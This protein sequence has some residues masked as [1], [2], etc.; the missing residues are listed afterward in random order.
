MAFAQRTD[1]G[2]RTAGEKAQMPDEFLTRSQVIP[3][4]NV[5]FTYLG[6][7]DIK[8]N[9]HAGGAGGDTDCCYRV[10]NGD[11]EI[12]WSGTDGL[13]DTG[14]LSMD[15]DR[16]HVAVDDEETGPTA[17]AGIVS[18]MKRYYGTAMFADIVHNWALDN[19]NN[20]TCKFTDTRVFS[21]GTGGLKSFPKVVGID[22]NTVRIY[23]TVLPGGTFSGDTWT[24]WQ[25][26][27]HGNTTSDRHGDISNLTDNGILDAEVAPKYHFVLM[28]GDQV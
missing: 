11:I 20:F 1:M 14:S 27:S 17:S 21:T 22:N 4:L 3:G 19:K 8:I 2:V 24:A 6:N 23:V 7:H 12:G 25:N 10:I 9:S 28:E 18:N 5:T 13:F 16:K 26:W 15:T